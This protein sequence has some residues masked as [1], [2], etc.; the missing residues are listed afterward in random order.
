MSGQLPAAGVV[1]VGA[2]GAPLVR[3][4]L[5]AGYE[6]SIFDVDAA[7][8]GLLTADGARAMNS[9]SAVARA[10]ELVI[11]CVPGPTEVE[12]C[13]AGS[14]GLVEGLREG[15][16][17]IE[18]ST[19]LPRTTRRVADVVR[20]RGAQIIDAPVSRGV[21]AAERGTLSIFVGGDEAVLE[22]CRGLLGTLGTDIVHLGPLGAGHVTKLLNMGL[23]AVHLLS[24]TEALTVA[25]RAGIARDAAIAEW[26]ASPASNFM[27][28]NHIPK[29]V[30]S[31]LYRSGFTLGLMHKDL[32]LL[33][34]LVREQRVAAVVTNRALDV[35]GI[36]LAQ[37][38]PNTDNMSIVPFCWETLPGCA[39]LDG[40]AN[41]EVIELLCDHLVVVSAFAVLEAVAVLRSQGLAVEPA[42]EV[43]A[44]SSGGSWVVERVAQGRAPVDVAD[45]GVVG[46]S[47][48]LLELHER[49]G[50]GLVG[51]VAY[52]LVRATGSSDAVA[53]G[54]R[55]WA[56]LLDGRT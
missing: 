42:L 19:S 12:L 37:L 14:G 21:P 26:N 22:Q 11:T 27:T 28:S 36:A 45:E 35:Y 6:V 8:V 16:V 15:A 10:S 44:S 18:M 4:L 39:N 31:G 46:P 13:I 50:T 7:A 43:I 20:S 5:Q 49:A 9:P 30:L 1:G 56:E 33:G 34:D 51:G 23:M 52:D 32:E 24:V 25:V 54:H 48:R 2:L 47:G 40:T 3:R 41:G 17:V 53:A 38:A 55:R 29:F